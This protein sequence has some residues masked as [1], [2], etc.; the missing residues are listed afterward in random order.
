MSEHEPTS[1]ISV[2]GQEFSHLNQETVDKLSET[3]KRLLID[4]TADNIAVLQ[5]MQRIFPVFVLSNESSTIQDYIDNRIRG[6]KLLGVEN[7]AE[8]IKEGDHRFMQMDKDGL[9]RQTIIHMSGM[10]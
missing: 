3:Q 7:V 9:I 10:I 6:L 2:L 1:T 8:E 5:W 4:S